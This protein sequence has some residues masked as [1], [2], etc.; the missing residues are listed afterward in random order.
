MQIEETKEKTTMT[1]RHNISLNDEQLEAVQEAVARACAEYSEDN[2]LRD[3]YRRLS[4]GWR[5]VNTKFV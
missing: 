4:A 2:I 1:D 3:A 5:D